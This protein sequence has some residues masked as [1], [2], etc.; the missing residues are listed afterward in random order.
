MKSP[1]LKMVAFAIVG[2]AAAISACSMTDKSGA[3]H[4]NASMACYWMSNLDSHWQAM[5]D[6]ETKTQCFEMDSC[7][8]GEGGSGGGCYKW[9]AGADAP[10][11]HW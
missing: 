8:G 4:F 6:L 9:A 1:L 7:S 3:S 10:G 11:Q 2:M 5:P